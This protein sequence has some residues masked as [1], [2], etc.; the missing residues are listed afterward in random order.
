MQVCDG[1]DCVARAVAVLPAVAEDQRSDSE[2][3][4]S[5]ALSS[6]GIAGARQ[7]PRSPTLRGPS[8]RCRI[9]SRYGAGE[10]RA[11]PHTKYIISRTGSS[12]QRCPERPRAA[13]TRSIKPG[14]YTQ[15]N[16]PRPGESDALAASRTTP[17][18]HSKG[19]YAHGKGNGICT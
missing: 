16:K 17:G 15:V 18:T 19:D 1:L 4:R 9:T 6:E 11:G 5:R 10:N 13:T 12:R 7:L 14:G 3:S 2:P 8:T